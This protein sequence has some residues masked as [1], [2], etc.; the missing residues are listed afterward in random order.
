MIGNAEIPRRDFLIGLGLLGASVATVGI[1]TVIKDLPDIHLEPG[2]S[3]SKLEQLLTYERYF[4]NPVPDSLVGGTINI[5]F[6]PYD[7]DPQIARKFVADMTELE[8]TNARTFIHDNVEGEIGFY[9]IYYLD[10]LKDFIIQTNKISPKPIQFA[11]NLFDT[12]NLLHSS[13]FNPIYGSIPLSH[14]YLR[15]ASNPQEVKQ[16]QQDF[17]TDPNTIAEFTKRIQ[18]IMHY[19]EPVSEFIN[20]WEVA[21]EPYPEFN[22]ND[23]KGVMTEWLHN[24]LPAIT[25][26]D[27]YTPISAGTKDATDYNGEE[28]V[29]DG[30][31]LASFHIY[32]GNFSKEQ[33]SLYKY[34]KQMQN[35]PNLPSPY[36]GEI[37]FP[38]KVFGYE[39]SP[40]AYDQQLARAI[41]DTVLN[42]AYI[43]DDNQQV[44]FGLSNI[45]IWQLLVNQKSRDGFQI[46]PASNPKAISAIQTA[47]AL[48]AS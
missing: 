47:Q 34:T 18:Y 24:V 46:D 21:N 6:A 15:Q 28:L 43:D 14:A 33:R 19:L 41:S 13:K 12:F 45:G 38:K 11:V 25:D 26:I 3:A 44:T 36:L 27:P 30:L 17:F 1:N 9:D 10:Q 2:Y 4:L 22:T 8:T 39:L 42:N 35:N 29:K 5:P 32:G 7:T 20:C 37:G 16:R 23:K 31:T 40:E 48:Y